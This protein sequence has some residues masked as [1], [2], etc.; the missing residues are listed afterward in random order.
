MGKK[1]RGVKVCELGGGRFR[2]VNEGD[3]G[4]VVGERIRG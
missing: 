4:E 3:E 2:G 1:K